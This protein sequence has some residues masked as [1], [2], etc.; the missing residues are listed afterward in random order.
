[1]ANSPTAAAQFRPPSTA[2]AVLLAGSPLMAMMFA[3]LGPILPLLAAQFG[4]A[5]GGAFAAQMIMTVPALGVI[6]GG[7]VAGIMVDRFG[8]KPV[9]LTGLVVFGLAGSSGLYLDNLPVLLVARMILGLAVAHVS[10]A[11]GVTVGSWFSGLSRARFLGFQAG[12]AGVSAL[13]F[14]LLSGVLAER[15]GWRAPFGIYLLAFVVLVFAI[16]GLKG[17]KVPVRRHEAGGSARDLFALW[18]VYLLALGLFAGY[19]MTSIQLS[20]LLAEDH[21][22]S[23]IQRSL[24]IA[25]GVLAGGVMGAAYGPI[26]ARL[27]T[28]L[29]PCLVIGMLGAGLFIIGISASVLVTAAGAVISGGGGGMIAPH[30]ETLILGRAP[31]DLR[32]RAISFMFTILYVADFLNPLIVTPLRLAL[33]I[34]GAFVAIG[35]VLLIAALAAFGFTRTSIAA[36]LDRH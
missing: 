17:S 28:R 7:L 16:V 12:T 15:V 22:D 10:T 23:P 9:L 8:A 13:V 26:L 32:A 5:N 21:V 35:A 25:G 29:M 4:G 36:S 11:I 18:P 14:L 27:G 24:V 30:I 34:H 19:F 2:L 6:G 20:F 1:M 3:A 33:G 31:L